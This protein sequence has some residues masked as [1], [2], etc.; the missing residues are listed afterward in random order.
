MIDT[1]LNY[2]VNQEIQEIFVNGSLMLTLVKNNGDRQHLTDLGQNQ[3]SL[4]GQMQDFAWQQ[5]IRL[6]PIRPAGGGVILGEN[7]ELFRWHCLLPPASTSGPL[8]S[9]RRLSLSSTPLSHFHDN[10]D[11]L[12]ELIALKSYDLIFFA[13]ETGAGKTTLLTSLA[14]KLL[15]EERVFI[16]ETVNEIHQVS[17][18][19]VQLVTR[20]ADIEGRGLLDCDDLAKECLRLRPDR[21]IFGEI[22]AREAR[23]LHHLAST[24]SA[25]V[26]TTIHTSNPEH[27][28]PRLSILGHLQE[29][30][31]RNLFDHLKVAYVQLQRENPR[32]K[33]ISYYQ[34]E[35]FSKLC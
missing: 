3:Q 9:L 25:G 34:E 14:A 35:G 18:H 24:A 32:L 23:S 26:W 22:R 27:L 19:W 13:G 6:D 33:G 28:I 4:I 21:F 7:K 2:F 20:N 11:L 31:W 29:S 12:Q 5:G 16:I 10:P 30:T 1:L 17:P 8:F 15:Y